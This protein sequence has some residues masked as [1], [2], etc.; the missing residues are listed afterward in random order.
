MDYKLFFFYYN[1]IVEGYFYPD[2]V[3][4][5]KLCNKAKKKEYKVL[6][7]LFPMV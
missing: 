3:K 7:P 2:V 4:Y 5:K 1:I 6:L